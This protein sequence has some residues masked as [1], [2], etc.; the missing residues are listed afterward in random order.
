MIFIAIHIVLLIMVAA[1]YLLYRTKEITSEQKKSKSPKDAL[2]FSKY[3]QNLD[4]IE[5]GEILLQK[6]DDAKNDAT[7]IGSVNSL[8]KNNIVIFLFSLEPEHCHIMAFV[9]ILV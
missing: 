9:D 7:N 1:L 6:D 5:I 2:Q 8:K 4:D 3:M